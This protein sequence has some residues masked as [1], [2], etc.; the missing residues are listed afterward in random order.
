MVCAGR[1]VTWLL[2]S[3]LLTCETVDDQLSL[4]L[5]TLKGDYTLVMVSDPN[6]FKAYQPDFIEPVHMDLKRGDVSSQEGKDNG[7]TTY[8]K[9][10]LFVKYQFFTPGM[11]SSK[12]A[13]T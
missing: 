12:I 6:E 4:V 7:N 2:I 11:L 9:R 8:D 10:P 13:R 5:D 3:P 1:I